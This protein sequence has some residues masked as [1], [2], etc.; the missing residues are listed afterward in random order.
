MKNN[1]KT[2]NNNSTAKLPIIAD[3]SFKGLIVKATI[4]GF[5]IGEETKYVT[6]IFKIKYNTTPIMSLFFKLLSPINYYLK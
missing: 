4:F 2:K 5:N 6:K 1:P 3:T